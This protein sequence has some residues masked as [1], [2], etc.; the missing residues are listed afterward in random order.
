MLRLRS[1]VF[2]GMTE[3]VWEKIGY[4]STIRKSP[5]ERWK[6]L[7][8]GV[9]IVAAILYLIVSSMQAGTRFFVTVDEVVGDARYVG[10]PVRVSGAVLGDTIR[11]DET[12]LTIEFTVV[13]VPDGQD[14]TGET[15]HAAVNDPNATRMRVRVENQTKPDLLRHE[16]QAILSGTLTTDGVFLAT[17]LNLKCPSRFIEGAPRESA[18]EPEG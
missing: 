11:Y 8:G 14:I 6:F 16:A 3:V 7:G 15:L 10:Q 2:I 12:T 17:E 18:S 4:A 5:G 9:L 1:G 13:H